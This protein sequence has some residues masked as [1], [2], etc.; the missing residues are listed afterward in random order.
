MSRQNGYT[1]TIKAFVPAPKDNFAAQAAAATMMAALT[2]TGELTPDFLALAKV[3]G[4][5]Q[6]KYGSIELAE[7]LPPTL[8]KT[9]AV[10][11]P[12]IGELEQILKE[13]DQDVIINPDGSVTAAPKPASKRK[14]A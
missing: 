9:D 4:K 10:D 13:D 1:V 12:T 8:P 11:R 6:A 2:Q 14:A 5:P 7:P 3:I